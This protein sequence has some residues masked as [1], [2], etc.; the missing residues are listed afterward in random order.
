M[1]TLITIVAKIFMALQRQMAMEAH[2][3]KK[4]ILES[5]TYIEVSTRRSWS[6]HRG[7]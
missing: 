6:F 2:V 7:R 1:I 3:G 4:L 5:D